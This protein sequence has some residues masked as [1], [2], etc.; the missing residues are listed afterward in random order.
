MACTS[1]LQQQLCSADVQQ[2]GASDH[3][4]GIITSIGALQGCHR[5]KKVPMCTNKAKSERACELGSRLAGISRT[6][7]RVMQ[8]H[9]ASIL[10]PAGNGVSGTCVLS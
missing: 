4:S 7:S 3:V 1:V 2:A 8:Q 5:W 6:Y 10:M 9:D